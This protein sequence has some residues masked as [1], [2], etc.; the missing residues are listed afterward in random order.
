MAHEDVHWFSSKYS[1]ILE[2]HGLTEAKFT[3]ALDNLIER[4]LS[5][6]Y[7]NSTEKLAFEQEQAKSDKAVPFL[8]PDEFRRSQLF[9]HAIPTHSG[10]S[11]RTSKQVLGIDSSRGSSELPPILIFDKLLKLMEDAQH[12]YRDFFDALAAQEQNQGSTVSKAYDMILKQD[13]LVELDA[14]DQK[15]WPFK[16]PFERALQ[17]LYEINN[18]DSKVHDERI[19]KML[20]PFVSSAGIKG[21][22]QDFASRQSDSDKV[23]FANLPLDIQNPLHPFGNTEAFCKEESNKHLCVGYVA[24]RNFQDH[25]DVMAIYWKDKDGEKRKVSSSKIYG[26]VDSSTNSVLSK[27]VH[28]MTREQLLQGA[29]FNPNC[30]ER[31][32]SGCPEDDV[33]G[34]FW[35]RKERPTTVSDGSFSSQIHD[36]RSLT[37]KQEWRLCN[38]VDDNL[39]NVAHQLPEDKLRPLIPR[40][41]GS[42]LKNVIPSMYIFMANPSVSSWASDLWQTP[43]LPGYTFKHGKAEKERVKADVKQTILA[44][45][46]NFEVGNGQFAGC[47]NIPAED[48]E[49]FG[50]N[51]LPDKFG[52]DE[53][54]DKIGGMQ[55]YSWL[56]NKSPFYMKVWDVPQYM[57][58]VP[59]V[60]EAA[61]LVSGGN[62]SGGRNS[63]SFG[64]SS[65][66]SAI[67]S[68]RSIRSL[69]IGKKDTE[70]FKETKEML[71]RTVEMHLICGYGP[72]I[73]DASPEQVKMWLKYRETILQRI[74]YHSSPEQEGNRGTPSWWLPRE[75]P[76]LL[77]TEK[78]RTVLEAS[79]SLKYVRSMVQLEAISIRLLT[80]VENYYEANPDENRKDTHPLLNFSIHSSWRLNEDKRDT[81]IL[82]WT[83]IYKAIHD[84]V[85]VA[86]WTAL[87]QD[88]RG[89]FGKNSSKSNQNSK[90]SSASKHA[91]ITL[92]EGQRNRLT[93]RFKKICNDV[94]KLAHAAWKPLSKFETYNK[95]LSKSAPE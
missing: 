94:F 7:M 22:M 83:V 92:N 20:I 9:G 72:H 11:R 62:F 44:S 38:F 95:I 88:P 70:L 4:E 3:E 78:G 19:L 66:L 86:N 5:L 47:P 67:S 32:V 80:E 25:S 43:S 73:V 93:A 2:Y 28:V 37:R 68:N 58:F 31:T 82:P 30:H 53:E 63:S 21:M 12:G 64:R 51:A 81:P 29:Y 57:R 56:N 89:A 23:S 71:L 33:P 39:H 91:Y 90:T 74:K 42:Q 24:K 14:T 35:R 40:L 6:A 54:E 1:S 36:T 49:Y 52:G 17:L 87:R 27:V 48:I 59:H 8:V 26:S 55:G 84:L 77:K 45:Q 75:A 61:S 18:S 41:Q 50:L 13:E 15:I 10:F 69:S 60:D 65:S 79:S 85:E 76:E 16:T 34:W 46:D